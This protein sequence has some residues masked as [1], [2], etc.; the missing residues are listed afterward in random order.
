MLLIVPY[1]CNVFFLSPL[2]QY[3]GHT[4]FWAHSILGTIRGFNVNTSAKTNGTETNGAGDAT[5]TR[6]DFIHIATGAATIVGVGFVAW[7]MIDQMNPSA[8]TMSLA[9]IEMDISNIEE[10]AQIIAKWRGKPVFVRHRTPAEITEANAVN[11]DEL[12]DKQTDNERLVPGPDGQLK[13]QYLV[14]VG[15]CTH[16]GCVPLFDP[17][18]DRGGEYKGWFCP[19]HGSHY[20]NSGRIRKGP[21]PT[22]LEIPPYWYV[23][24]TVVEIGKEALT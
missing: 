10:G 18:D 22:N 1:Q 4:V 12:K 15:V 23:S 5:P 8:D 2:A 9:T 21:A 19:C 24:D 14:T 7:P 16:L 20:D 6:R 17:N 11:L 3:F 13:P